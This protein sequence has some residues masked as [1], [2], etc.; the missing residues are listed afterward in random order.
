VAEEG[1]EA[2]LHGGGGARSAEVLVEP[3]PVP[4]LE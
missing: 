2:V 4:G 3:E 1:E